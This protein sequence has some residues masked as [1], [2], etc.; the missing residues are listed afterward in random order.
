VGV[1]GP[2]GLRKKEE[3]KKSHW[4][5]QTFDFAFVLCVSLRLRWKG[6]VLGQRV[7]RCSF[8]SFHHHWFQTVSKTP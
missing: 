3:E 4:F 5:Q 6:R 1:E 8:G 2:Q 7:C